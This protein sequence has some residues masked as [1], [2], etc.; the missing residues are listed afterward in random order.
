MPACLI[1]LDSI[2]WIIFGEACYVMKLP[3]M[4]SSPASYHFSLL[5]PNILLSN[6]LSNTIN[7]CFSLI[8]REKV[9][10]PYKTTGKIMILY[11][12]IFELLEWRQENKR[13]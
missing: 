8:V 2:A 13:L 7:H 9:S 3:I 5:G 12:L 10:H 11:I 4:Q 1:L 6:L